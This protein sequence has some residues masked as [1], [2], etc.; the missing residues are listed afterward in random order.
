[1]YSTP[2]SH[3]YADTP[4][5]IATYEWSNDGKKKKAKKLQ[6]FFSQNH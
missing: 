3:L 6:L 4:P 5:F 1:L 2:S